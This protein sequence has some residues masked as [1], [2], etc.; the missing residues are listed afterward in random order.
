M[1]LVSGA[2]TV[3]QLG[4]ADNSSREF[5][6]YTNGEFKTSETLLRSAGYDLENRCFTSTVP[7]SG[8]IVEK[9]QIPAGISDPCAGNN[10]IVQKQIIRWQE[11]EAGWRM[12]EF[13]LIVPYNG[14]NFKN[15]RITPNENMDIDGK[16]WVPCRISVEL[17]GKRRLVREVPY[18]L[19]PVLKKNPDAYRF[20]A[21]FP[22]QAGEN[23]LAI[24]DIG[25]NTYGRLYHF[26]YL[27]LDKVEKTEFLPPV[28][29]FRKPVGFLNDSVYD[30]GKKAALGVE[31]FNLKP[32]QKNQ[33]EIT[34]TDFFGKRKQQKISVGADLNG[35]CRLEVPVP[36]RQSGHFVV[37]VKVN[38]SLAGTTR[39]AGVRLSA[40]L[41]Q[42]EKE[43]SF[44][45][46]SGLSY[47]YFFD[48][49]SDRFHQKKQAAE[50]RRWRK[51]L[52]LHHERIH[53]LVWYFVEP[54]QGKF[55]WDIWDE[56]IAGEKAS[57]VSVQLTLLGTP[58]WLLDKHYPDRKY[59]NIF[60]HMFAVPPDMQEWG[61]FCG[62]VAERYGD[63][64][65]EFELWNEA[66]GHSL[67][68]QN[69]DADAFCE[70]LKHGSKAIKSVHPDAKIVAETL[71][72]RQEEFVKKLFA[73]G[74]A[75]YVDIHADH[76]ITDTR[77]D[78]NNDILKKYAPDAVWISNEN[79]GDTTT[80]PFG[81]IDEN[82][83]REAAAMLIRNVCYAAT[84]GVRRLYNFVICGG[85]WRKWG[86]VGPDNTP[87]YTFSSF[88]TLINRC[89]GAV[90]VDCLQYG[91]GTELF[92]FRYITPERIAEKG[93]E[94]LA[95]L[96]GGEN[97][98]DIILPTVSERVL[99]TDIMDNT[100]ILKA[101]NRMLK[102]TPGKYPLF[103]TGVD[104]TALRRLDSLKIS[105]PKTE[106]R[107]GQDI[108]LH[109]AVGAEVLSAE[110]TAG[111]SKISLKA[112]E[113]KTLNIPTSATGR[114]MCIKVPVKGFLKLADRT[115]PV[116]RVFEFWMEKKTP[117]SNLLMPFSRQDWSCWGNQKTVFAS[118]NATLEMTSAKGTGALRPRR[119]I[120]VIPGARYLLAFQAYGQ[121]ILRVMLCGFNEK[122]ERK[123]VL[124]NLFSD[125][126]TPQPGHYQTIWLCPPGIT[127][128]ELDFYEY[129]E[130]GHF[131]LVSPK[132]CRLSPG[133]PLARSLNSV[134]VGET[135]HVTDAS[136][137]NAPGN[138]VAA[139]F[140]VTRQKN[141]LNITVR[142]KDKKHHG[143]A[144]S[145]EL[146]QGDSVQLDFDLGDGRKA[147]RTVQFA[148]GM[149]EG[150]LLR[151]RFSILPSEDIVP[152]YRVGENPDGTALSVTR[153]NNETVYHI[154]IEA[155]AI[156]PQLTLH[157][158][159]NIGFSLLVNNNDGHGRTG[160]L[161]WSAG[162]GSSQDS[163]LF[164]EL[165]L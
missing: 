130:Q 96:C 33:L 79:K 86:V 142:V 46:V 131:T 137:L 44:L 123:L 164:G 20:R 153:Q 7:A 139:A 30:T 132:F 152:S 55:D 9:P 36:E 129:A 1:T 34:F 165:K 54:Q 74:V 105:A 95:V 145:S 149:A 10:S 120:S 59:A 12:L 3:W 82:A 155:S 77:I 84:H 49:S 67:F 147:V 75:K 18:D 126:L 89:A 114:D 102:I 72:P 122:K 138:P 136:K 81:Q 87:K 104:V 119:K 16:T 97:S 23:A 148:F 111:K 66:S 62:R 94:Y 99:L 63:Y 83:R 134:K 52:Q 45:G 25:G 64:V 70:L 109:F 159:M 113:R 92:L 103:L 31:L 35:F 127:E 108:I 163:R 78:A 85:T 117:G 8:G 124:H 29:E 106:L 100:T 101:G 60:Q 91:N 162:I 140:S 133:K 73:N 56:M 26:D 42:Q 57:G 151:H 2:S 38:G 22:V 28:A 128:I 11:K 98:A 88:K 80:D 121:G 157:K 156:H 24:A 6:P 90:P 110:L 58:R 154:S 5:I 65:K 125:T 47:G 37:T 146:W 15:H 17:P 48:P 144:P 27:R 112:D 50:Y 32:N 39:I 61:R 158:G 4:K 150:K 115:L 43:A 143:V 41:D 160:F 135:A 107:P 53:S 69:G 118:Q 13:R 116:E 68:W 141:R 21:V 40:P 51:I 19:A 71:W 93:G 161:Q 76:Y 14:K